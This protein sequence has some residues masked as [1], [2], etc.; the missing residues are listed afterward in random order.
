[1]ATNLHDFSDIG[2]FFGLH[3]FLNTHYILG[4]TFDG[5]KDFVT[6]SSSLYFQ[7]FLHYS[8]PNSH[9][10]NGLKHAF[11]YARAISIFFAQFYPV[12]CVEHSTY[13]CH[14]NLHCFH[15]DVT[16]TY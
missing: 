12:F 16:K 14:K 11:N 8:E 7:K 9:S 13:Q 1:M 4:A 10:R 2:F 15:K 6:M 5:H 3:L